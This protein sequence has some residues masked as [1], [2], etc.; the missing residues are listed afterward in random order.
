MRRLSSDN[1]GSLLTDRLCGGSV[2]GVGVVDGAVE[3]YK[4]YWSVATYI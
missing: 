3:G 1:E 2:E 4:V